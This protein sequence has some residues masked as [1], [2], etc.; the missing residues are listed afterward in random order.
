MPAIV[1]AQSLAA[2]SAAVDTCS[3]PAAGERLK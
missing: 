2:V 3:D 1:S